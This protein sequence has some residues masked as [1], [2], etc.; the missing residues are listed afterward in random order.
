M[1]SGAEMT[2]REVGI[3][4]KE[5]YQNLTNPSLPSFSSNKLKL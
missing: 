3:G 5:N 2:G 4:R 1:I